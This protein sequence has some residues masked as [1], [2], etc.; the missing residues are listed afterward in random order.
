MGVQ[1]FDYVDNKTTTMFWYVILR[2]EWSN[3]KITLEYLPR[4]LNE[5][6]VVWGT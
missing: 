2:I 1:I 4:L 5:R 6:E 3:C